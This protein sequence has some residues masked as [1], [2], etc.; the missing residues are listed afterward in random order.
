MAGMTAGTGNMW[1]GKCLVENDKDRFVAVTEDAS[2]DL[3]AALQNRRIF[4]AQTGAR[5]VIEGPLSK[6]GG[7]ANP[8]LRPRTK[9]IEMVPLRQALQDDTRPILFDTRPLEEGPAPLADLLFDPAARDWPEVPPLPQIGPAPVESFALLDA[10]LNPAFPE[11]LEGSGLAHATL[12]AGD[13]AAELSDVAPWLV[14]LE[15]DAALTRSLLSDDPQPVG[16]W[17]LQGAIFLRSR[18][19]LHGLRRNLRSFTR[20][21]GEAGSQPFFFRFYSASVF[22]T[23]VPAMDSKVQRGLLAGI[24]LIVTPGD[25]RGRTAMVVHRGQIG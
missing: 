2:P 23:A 9:A 1:R 25:V 7:I 13:A 22:R 15:P 10:A 3:E 8:A 4:A 14:R 12:F 16:F 6:E 18:L 17:A 24:D 21:E 5:L 11:A 20:L 19:G